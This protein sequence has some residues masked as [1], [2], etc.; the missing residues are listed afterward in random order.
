MTGGGYFPV[1]ETTGFTIESLQD[2]RNIFGNVPIVYHFRSFRLVKYVN[3]EAILA[4]K[5][6][7]SLKR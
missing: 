2:Y 5:K 4:K 1:V 6:E 7:F 3:T